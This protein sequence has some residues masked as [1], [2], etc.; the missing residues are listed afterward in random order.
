MA[1]NYKDIVNKALED[2][3][4]KIAAEKERARLEQE[5]KER[6]ERE[7]REEAERRERE[8]REAE[9]KRRAEEEERKRQKQLEEE[10]RKQEQREA[11]ARRHAEEEERR[12]QEEQRLLN[13]KNARTQ[14]YINQ[15]ALLYPRMQDTLKKDKKASEQEIKSIISEFESLTKQ[16][17]FLYNSPVY[18]EACNAY[19]SLKILLV[20][21]AENKQKKQKAMKRIRITFVAVLAAGAIGGAVYGIHKYTST[22]EYI[23]KAAEKKSQ[24][25]AAAQAKAE[26]KAREKLL[27]SYKVGGF[28]EAGVIFYDKGEYSDGWRFL[29]VSKT[30]IANVFFSDE[31][32]FVDGL[33]TELGTGDINTKLIIEKLGNNTAAKIASNYNGGG[34]NDWYLGNSAEMIMLYNNL[35]DKS[36]MRK[37]LDTYQSEGKCE[38]MYSKYW[39]DYNNEA[40][41]YLCSE[42]E[43]ATHGGTVIFSDSKLVL[44]GGKLMST[45]N[46]WTAY[47]H[48]GYDKYYNY[49]RPIRNF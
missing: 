22:E 5:E 11:E 48:E 6:K 43:N 41:S 19:N 2:Q 29:E 45:G 25:E 13:E 36:K 40:I 14:N 4:E 9:E 30:K 46:T 33:Q 32:G 1:F 31:D 42:Q 39:S 26:E 12:R 7:A 8:A 21:K 28:R 24:K 3:A 20:Q 34:K 16:D 17:V 35:V 27:K 18:S 44:D 23:A 15:L 10:R 49:I 47:K 38:K 37:K